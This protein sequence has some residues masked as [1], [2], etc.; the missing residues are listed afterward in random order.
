MI[1]YWG[2]PALLNTASFTLPVGVAVAVR[3]PELVIGLALSS[4]TTIAFGMAPVL[5]LLRVDVHGSLHGDLH[6]TQSRG[7]SAIRVNLVMI[8]VLLAVVVLTG[9][10]LFVNSFL[11]VVALPMGFDSRGVVVAEVADPPG[12]SSLPNFREFDRRFGD[13]ARARFNDRPIALASSMPFVRAPSVGWTLIVPDG[14][15]AGRV[16]NA[17]IRAV[18]PE[19]FEVLRVPLLRGRLLPPGRLNGNRRVALVNEQFVRRCARGR[20]SLGFGIRSG[21]ASDPYTIVGVVGDTRTVRLGFA[22]YPAV[23]V[24]L[25]E[26]PSGRVAVVIRGIDLAAVA[27]AVREAAGAIDPDI[28]LTNIVAVDAEMR[29]RENTRYFYVLVMAVFGSLA[30]LLAVGGIFGVVAHVTS[31]RVREFGIRLALGA[32]PAQLNWLV[33]RQGLRPVMAGLVGG[34]IT[35]YWM[36]EVLRANPVFMGQLYQTTPHDVWTWG[37]ATA[38]LLVVSA[39][40]CWIP[41]S[42]AGRVDPMT[43]LNVD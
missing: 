34:V 30:G 2:V 41:A 15:E 11:K 29:R 32:T 27:T 14:D 10:G 12:P 23:Y 31:L 5:V 33:M 40:A 21:E 7:V 39:V 6:V 38:G 19:Y 8:E 1:A 16:C 26:R 3:I 24:P 35:A 9:A 13:A 28:P 17:E 37:P 20:N 4:L 43:V 36:A 42:R 22:P 18:S 25:D